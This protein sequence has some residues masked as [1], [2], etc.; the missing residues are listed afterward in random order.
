MSE[1]IIR[2]GDKEYKLTEA[3]I[4]VDLWEKVAVNNKLEEL[5]DILTKEGIEQI[6]SFYYDLLKS[7]YP[8]VTKKALGK[9]PFY[10]LGNPFIMWVAG[11]L[12]TPP[13]G[14]DTEKESQPALETS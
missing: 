6:K 14:F 10:Q 3:D 5:N 9:M 8:E 7:R 1:V 2:A 4:D 12:L 11:N 13:L